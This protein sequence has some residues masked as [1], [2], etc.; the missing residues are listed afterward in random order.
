MGSLSPA[1]PE[2]RGGAYSQKTRKRKG[3]NE[4]IADLIM[5]VTCVRSAVVMGGSIAIII[6]QRRHPHANHRLIILHYRAIKLRAKKPTTKIPRPP[7]KSGLPMARYVGFE[8]D[9]SEKTKRMSPVVVVGS[10]CRAC[11][12]SGSARDRRAKDACLA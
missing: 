11:A 2:S 12:A 4:M 6:I 9:E 7:P 3:A 10:C 5:I 1:R 8:K